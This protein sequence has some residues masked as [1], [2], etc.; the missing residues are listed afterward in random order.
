MLKFKLEIK[1]LVLQIKIGVEEDERLF[2]QEI[3]C[4]LT[5]IFNKIP[6]GCIN[7]EISQVFCYANIVKI[8]EEYIEGREFRLI[9]ELCFLLYNHIL[10]SINISEDTKL[11]ITICKN[12]PI[13]NIKS[14]CCF[15]INN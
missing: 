6:E 12:P 15:S 1:K 13:E 5:I 11:S 14:G 4:D 7:G 8:I 3:E 9:E 10:E 2:P